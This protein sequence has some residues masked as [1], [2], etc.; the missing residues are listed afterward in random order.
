MASFE[1]TGIEREPISRSRASTLFAG[2]IDAADAEE[3]SHRIWENHDA[4]SSVGVLQLGT[5]GIHRP[6]LGHPCD[7]PDVHEHLAQREAAMPS[8]MD[9]VKRLKEVQTI[10]RKREGKNPHYLH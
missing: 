7:D 5:H 8:K 4:A 3:R 9:E 2:G 6:K 1:P 10:L